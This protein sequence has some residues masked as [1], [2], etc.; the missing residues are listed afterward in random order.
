MMRRSS[1]RKSGFERRPRRPE[2]RS[3][4]GAVAVAFT[5]SVLPV[6]GCGSTPD[7]GSGKRF[8]GGASSGSLG[9]SG[10]AY[11]NGSGGGSGGGSIGSSSGDA[12]GGGGGAGGGGS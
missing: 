9:S 7:R 2:M 1:V 10:G 4:I 5:L 8:G 6:S 3:A 11:G 12:A